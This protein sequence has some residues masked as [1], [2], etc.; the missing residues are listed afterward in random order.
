MGV[1]ISIAGNRQ[2]VEE[3]CPERIIREQTKCIWVGGSSC[4][5][6]KGS[7]IHHITYWPFE[8]DLSMRNFRLLTKALFGVPAAYVGSVD[9]NHL[10]R[11]LSKIN[12]ASLV[13]PARFM[14]GF[15]RVSMIDCPLSEEQAHRYFQSLNKIA[16]EAIR[17]ACLIWWA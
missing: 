2:Y 15:G 13:R 7:G 16:D 4:P 3:H 1:T 5:E 10:K 9:P 12:P 8:L 17:R 6:C 11:A 14:T